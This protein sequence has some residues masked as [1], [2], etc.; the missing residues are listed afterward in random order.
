VV[1]DIL[2]GAQAEVLGIV[3]GDRIVEYDGRPI[4]TIENLLELTAR[5]EPADA[6]LVL[7][8]VREGRRIRLTAMPGRLGVDVV[9]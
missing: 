8:L 6:N 3:P 5:T 7:V 1:Q 2:P 4:R 9:E